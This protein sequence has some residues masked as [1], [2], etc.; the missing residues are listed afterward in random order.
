MLKLDLE[1]VDEPDIKLSTSVGSSK[2]QECFR[3][4]Q[5]STFALLTT[6]K[7]LTVWIIA[8][9]GKFLKRW[10][11]QTALP[12]FLL[13]KMYA[14]K[15]AKLELDLEQWTDSKLE[16]HNSKLYIVTLPI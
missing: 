1:K 9:C 5:K 12:N 2:Q 3:K 13:G 6:P 11:Y 4:K 15:E 16:R 7:P 8:N 14:G 10:E